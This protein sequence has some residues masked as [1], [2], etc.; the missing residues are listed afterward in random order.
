MTREALKQRN[1]KLEK[2]NLFLKA[3]RL[4]LTQ[5]QKK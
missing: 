2:D 3:D 4:L 5:L 1:L